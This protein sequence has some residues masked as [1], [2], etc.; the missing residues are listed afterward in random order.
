MFKRIGM[1][2]AMA[3][4][5]FG[6]FAGVSAAVGSD[7]PGRS[8]SPDVSASTLP[9]ATLD[10]SQLAAISVGLRAIGFKYGIDPDA[11]SG[12]V[13]VANTEAGPVF[14]VPGSNGLCLVMITATGPAASCGNPPLDGGRTVSIFSGDLARGYDVGAGVYA[15]G[16]NIAI[17]L[18]SGAV[19]RPEMVPGGFTLSRNEHVPASDPIA[20]VG[21]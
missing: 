16:A 14:A 20:E 8:F 13:L 15:K 17:H 1:A 5:G 9:A 10:S 18:K 12:I 4:V 6:A 7:A 3:V 2:I 21:S 11:V 19:V